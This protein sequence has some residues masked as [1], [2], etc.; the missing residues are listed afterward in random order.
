M[1][2]TFLRISSATILLMPLLAMA[3]VNPNLM[4]PTMLATGTL[5]I[6]STI[7]TILF[8]LAIAVF[9]WGIVK[10]ILAAGDPEKVKEA[11]GIIIWGVIA[12][13]VLAS[14]FGLVTYLRTVFGVDGS[15]NLML[16]VPGV[17]PG[18]TM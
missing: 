3:Q 18:T 17:T 12:I 11:R 7:V 16:T 2:K 15:M 4:G 9:A 8:V 10:M 1:T 6:L 14:L 5:T 13:A